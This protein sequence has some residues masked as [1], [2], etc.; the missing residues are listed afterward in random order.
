[1]ALIKKCI[2]VLADT[3][4]LFHRFGNVRL[5][6]LHD[7]GDSLTLRGRRLTFTMI[8]EHKALKIVNKIKYTKCWFWYALWAVSW[9]GGLCTNLRSIL[10][11]RFSIGPIGKIFM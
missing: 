8:E 4:G 2:A 3:L 6:R 5:L 1:M 11:R 7:T 10:L 9:G